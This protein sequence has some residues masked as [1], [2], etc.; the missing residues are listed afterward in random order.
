MNN[1]DEKILLRYFQEECTP[2]EEIAIN[3][4]LE[5]SPENRNVF[6]GLELTLQLPNKKRY[7]EATFLRNAEK[8][9]MARVERAEKYKA[10]MRHKA[11]VKNLAYGWTAA[12]VVAIAIVIG[13]FSI[14]DDVINRQIIVSVPAGDPVKELILA[15]GTKV[16]LNESSILRYPENFSSKNRGV[17]LDGEAYFEVVSDAK[18]S[19]CVNSSSINTKVLGTTFNMKSYKRERIAEVTLIKGAIEVKGNNDEG[20]IVLVPGQRAEIDLD[21]RR[22]TVKSVNAK[23]DAVWRNNLLPFDETSL[24]DIARTLERFYDIK[25][26]FSK[27]VNVSNCYSGVIRKKDSIEEVLESLKNSI[28]IKYSINGS[29]IYISNAD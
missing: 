27:G 28:H 26:T 25:I 13:V 21:K 16:W 17:Y 5:E 9:L 1:I 4:W 10:Q 20:Q 11:R 23:M 22:M 18:S 2:E 29:D 19:F 15:D 6:F 14:S 12:A 24:L 7:E 3:E 8:S